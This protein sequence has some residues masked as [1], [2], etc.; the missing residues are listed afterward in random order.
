MPPERKRFWE[1][2]E[3]I[4]IENL[5]RGPKNMGLT[6]A[7]IAQ[8]VTATVE[9]VLACRLETNSP[10]FSSS[11]KQ[12]VT[13]LKLFIVKKREQES[14]REYLSHFNRTIL[15]KPRK[16]FDELL[17]RTEKYVNVEELLSVQ[18]AHPEVPR[19]WVP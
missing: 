5:Y 6:A 19:P 15:E 12:P 4:G 16:T 2:R 10:P 7:Q 1:T 17:T 13:M 18:R 3:D 14:L 11:K 9:Q 8:L